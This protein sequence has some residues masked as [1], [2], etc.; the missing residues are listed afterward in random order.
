MTEQLSVH[1]EFKDSRAVT[2][3][4]NDCLAEIELDSIVSFSVY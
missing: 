4:E 1:C 2:H 3:E